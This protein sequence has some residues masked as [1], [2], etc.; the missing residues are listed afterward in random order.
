MFQPEAAPL[1][2]RQQTLAHAF[3]A[4]HARPG[5]F[6]MPNAW[7][8]GGAVVLAETGFEAIATTSAGIAFSLGKPDYMADSA[9]AVTREEMFVRMGEIVR[10]V[11]IP[12]NGDL[13]AGYGDSPEAVAETVR[14][15]VEIGLAGGN[16]EDADAQAGGLYGEDLAVDRIAGARTAVG[17]APFVLTARTDVFL[18]PGGDLATCIRRANRFLA[19][20][21][22]C[23]FTPGAPDLATVATLAREIEGPVNIVMGLGAVPSDANALRAAG[24]QR[25][26]LGGTFARATLAFI[27]KGAEELRDHGTI[28]F[29][30][31]QTP[32][33]EL[34][35]LFARACQDH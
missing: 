1:P 4:L 33:G 12:V 20:G 31:G 2:D 22:D 17:D 10:A 6:V 3:K 24:A 32:Q 28:G 9:L 8:A 21:A 11:S 30:A 7:D 15:A 16:I 35:A 23:V 5:G 27:R 34:N 26:S 19:A 29:A 14:M 13:E 18:T 25:I